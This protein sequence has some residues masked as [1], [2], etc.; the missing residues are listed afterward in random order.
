MLEVRLVLLAAEEVKITDLEVRPEVT[1]GISVATLGVL[2]TS[3]VICKPLPHVVVAEVRRVGGKESLRLRP[4][5]WDTL[6]RI[7]EVDGEAVCLVAVFHVAEHIV[8]DVAEE[9]D[10]GLN[11]PVVAVAGES[12]VLVEH[13]AV[14]A[15][16]LVVGD[17]GAVLNVLLF[18]NL[19]RFVEELHV[20]PAGHFPVLLGNEFYIKLA[21][22]PREVIDRVSEPY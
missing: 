22:C 19:G 6:R 1:S 10:V 4:E 20:D 7:V 15:T 16:H 9:L 13:A 14:P 17:L 2:R 21:I 12:G 11:A 8:V 3:D 5:G 18:Q